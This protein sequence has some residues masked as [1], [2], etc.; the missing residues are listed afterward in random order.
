MKKHWLPIIVFFVLAVA[1]VAVATG[2]G[3]TTTTTATPESTT[4]A[5]GDTTTTAAEQTTTTAAEEEV[6]ATGPN[7]EAAD[8]AIAAVTKSDKIET[9]KTLVPGKLQAGSDT[10]FPP[11][12]YSDG[13]G[14]YIGFDVDILTSLCKKMGLELVMVSTAWDGIIPALVS[15]RFDIIGSAM[16]ITDERKEQINFSDAYY[17]ND[18]AITTPVDKPIENADG[19]VGKIVGVQVDTT[20]QFAV[21][22]IEGIKEMK[23][24][25][26]IILAIQ[27]LEAGRTEAVVNDEPSNAY[28]I[29]NK[30]NLANTGK[31]VVDDDYGFGIKKENTELLEAINAAL[32]EIKADGTYDLIRAKWFGKAQ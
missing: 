13:K 6:G 31:I 8:A 17:Q 9:P 21:E 3:E 16:S 27:D 29:R 15:D 26:N 18:L 32:G 25:E 22:K 19:L 14:G 20:G 23:K 24:Y 5:A 12:E 1:L 10:A 4:T 2:C 30:P 7:A 11:F 28:Q